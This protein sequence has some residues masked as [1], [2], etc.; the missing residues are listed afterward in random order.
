MADENSCI[1]AEITAGDTATWR[2]TLALY[3]ASAG[4]VL[5]YKLVSRS[6]AFTVTATADGDNFVAAVPATDTATW[7]AGQYQVQEY[8]TLGTERH[9]IGVTALRVLP[10]LAVATT[11][12]DNRSHAQKVLDSLEAWLES[13][14]PVA[15]AME[16][17]GRKI[18]WY[19]LADLLKLRDRYRAEVAAEQRSV[20]PFGARILVQL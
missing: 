19:P 1:P 12:M 2:R 13:K 9:T 7:A 8:V 5:A 14:A 16:I 4:W 20:R 18:S 17:N 6:A 3:P 10:D 11:G 15:G